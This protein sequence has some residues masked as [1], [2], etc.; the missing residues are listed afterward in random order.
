[1]LIYLSTQLMS[2]IIFIFLFA[3]LKIWTWMKFTSILNAY[4]ESQ[5]IWILSY[6]LAVNRNILI[7]I[8]SVSI[9]AYILTSTFHVTYHLFFFFVVLK[10]ELAK[11]ESQYIC[12][13]WYCLAVNRKYSKPYFLLVY[14]CL[15]T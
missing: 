9:C 2:R 14:M 6:C 11:R 4:R 1:M 8:F 5:Y 3:C 12:N 13:L 7:L 10:Y 15:C